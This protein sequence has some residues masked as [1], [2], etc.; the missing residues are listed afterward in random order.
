M[1][2]SNNTFFVN[3]VQPNG[4]LLAFDDVVAVR[5]V[6]R[7]YN[8]LMMKDYMPIIG[9]V[10]GSID[11]QGKTSKFEMKSGTAYYINHENKFTLIIKEML[12][13]GLQIPVESVAGNAQ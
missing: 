5:V 12:E 8:L 10:Q 3:V 11:I 9:E 7:N 4:E 6:D 13:G 2:D 1:Q